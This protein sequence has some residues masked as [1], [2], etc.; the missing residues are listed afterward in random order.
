MD[1]LD[2]RGEW[3]TDD[4]FLLCFNAWHEAVDFRIP[5]GEYGSNWRV[6]VDTSVDSNEEPNTELAGGSTLPVPAR[7]LVVLQ[8]SAE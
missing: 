7:S 6:V 5:G 2:R 3:V 1:E 8:R 4:S